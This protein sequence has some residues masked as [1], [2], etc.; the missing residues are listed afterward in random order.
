LTIDLSGSSQDFQL[1]GDGDPLF[2]DSANLDNF[3]V[4]FTFSGQGNGSNTGPILPGD[5]D[6]HPFGYGTSHFGPPGRAG[7]GLGQQDFY[8]ALRSESTSTTS[9]LNYCA[10]TQANSVSATDALLSSTSGFGTSTATFDIKGIPNQPGVLCL[11]PNPANMPFGCG[12]R[13]INGAMTRGQVMFPT[14]NQL[15]GATFDMSAGNTV[16]IQYF[17][18]DP[19]NLVG[20]SSAFSLSNGVRP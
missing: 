16:N 10:T 11:V 17:Y 12:R 20:C 9:P 15:F 5:P 2:D 7:T 1:T 3:S 14:F 13:C 19:A 18:R 6:N 8:V 4:G